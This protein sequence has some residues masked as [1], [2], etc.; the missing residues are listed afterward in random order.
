MSTNQIDAQFANNITPASESD[1]DSWGNFDEVK[2]TPQELIENVQMSPIFNGG[3]NYASQRDAAIELAGK[4]HSLYEN[5]GDAFKK[6]EFGVEI[7]KNP[8]A[9][10]DFL[11]VVD[12]L[13]PSYTIGTF[14]TSGDQSISISDSIKS[15][16]DSDFQTG[17]HSHPYG[18]KDGLSF[19][20]FQMLQKTEPADGERT[21]YLYSRGKLFEVSL[22]ESAPKFESNVSI[23]DVL[24]KN[25]QKLDD[26][27]ARMYDYLTE[28]L[29][30]DD[31]QIKLVRDF[32]NYDSKRD[33]EFNLQLPNTE[34]DYKVI[35]KR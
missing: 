18:E 2:F 30:K 14:K 15:K 27:S 13:L 32:V 7:Q 20:D 35:L 29:S 22:K 24:H 34:K 1:D 5:G 19:N 26:E 16:T 12:K 17:L 28:R 11:G 6:T 25:K 31:L 23:F 8:K 10:W 21:Q 9:D 4:I 3:K 33:V